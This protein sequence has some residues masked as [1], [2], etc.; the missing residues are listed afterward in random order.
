MSD[1]IKL[2][3]KHLYPVSKSLR[4]YLRQYGRVATL[5]LEY[6]QLLDASES[7]PL[8][9]REGE[10][11]LWQSFVYEP[12]LWK[13][14]N[15]A[16][17]QIYVT[18][19]AAGNL[20]S[21]RHLKC[22]RVDFCAFGNSQPFRIRIVN[23]YND[24]HDYFY[25]KR[26]DASRVYGL[27]LEEL[28]SPNNI[29]Y[30]VYEQTLIEEHVVGVPGDMFARQ[31]FPREDL[32]KVR[33]A[34]EFVKFN[35]R[36]FVRLLGDMRAYNYVIRMTPDFDDRQY[37]V[38]TI[39]FDQQSY[40]GR[41]RFYLPQFFK[42]NAEVVNLCLEHLEPDSIEQYRDEER[43][44]I[45]RRAAT[46]PFRLSNLKASMCA[47]TLSTEAKIAELAAEL[48]RHH[49]DESLLECRDMGTLTF[50]HLERMLDGFGGEELAL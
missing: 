25:I 43:S 13:E 23:T 6:H 18:L 47:D 49:G 42:D 33:I 1:N 24:N 36:C 41:H 12:E 10:D 31:Y 46:L 37:R 26:A 40:E 21:M 34:K 35:E 5:P 4:A 29:H 28:L 7:F 2:K 22:D 14:L 15:N 32:N 20:S 19:K 44:L 3:R 30:L 39:D 45:A 27:E 17:S 11:T 38:R 16:L 48:A 9:D 50:G 8:Y